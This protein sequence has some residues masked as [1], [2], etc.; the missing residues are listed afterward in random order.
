MHEVLVEKA[1][2]L[3]QHNLSHLKELS[4]SLSISGKDNLSTNEKS[5]R[6]LKITSKRRPGVID[7]YHSG[8]RVKLVCPVDEPKKKRG[9]RKP[10][11]TTHVENNQPKVKSSN[12]F[13]YA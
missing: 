1:L 3:F 7:K 9:V 2:T 5:L 11:K 12:G 4:Q 8:R 10:K 6:P 13:N